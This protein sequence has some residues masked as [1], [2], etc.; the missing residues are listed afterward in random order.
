MYSL[1][2]QLKGYLCPVHHLN[3]HLQIGISRIIRIFFI[4]LQIVQAE[5]VITHVI[6]GSGQLDTD[7]RLR[8]GITYSHKVGIHLRRFFPP[9]FLNGF[10]LYKQLSAFIYH[11]FGNFKGTCFRVKGKG[12]SRPCLCIRPQ[13][14]LRKPNPRFFSFLHTLSV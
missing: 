1:F 8:Q 2:I 4:I 9:A 12:I 3:S 13:G 10:H 11:L 14:N 5:T 6:F 7:S